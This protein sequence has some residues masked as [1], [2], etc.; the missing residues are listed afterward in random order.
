MILLGLDYETTWEDPVD[1]SK[2]RIIEAGLVLYDTERAMPIDMAN[3]LVKGPEI[4]EDVTTLTGITQEDLSTRGL[5][6]NSVMDETNRMLDSCDY[7]VAHNGNKFD[8]IVYESECERASITPVEKPWIDTRVDIDFPPQ[9]SSRKLVHLAAE[10]GFANPF[11]HRALFDVLTMLRVLQEYDINEV[12]E[13]S[14]EP[15]YLCTAKVT[16][17]E[18]DLAKKRGYFWNPDMKTWDKELK[19]SMIEKEI[20]EAPFKVLTKEL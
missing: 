2:M 14:K 4:T 1:P 16:F 10:H 7:V 18:K 5:S 15:V 20:Q 13:R 3:Y 17:H 9:I 12:V 11:S 19:E 8:K 6:L